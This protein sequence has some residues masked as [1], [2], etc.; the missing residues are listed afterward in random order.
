MAVYIP[1]GHGG[2]FLNKPRKT[3]PDGCSLTVI[4]TCGGKTYVG[5]HTNQTFEYDKINAFLREHPEKRNIFSDP[6]ANAADLNQIFGSVAI[7]GPGEKYPNIAYNLEL[8]W[9]NSNLDIIDMRYSGLIPFD[10]YISPEFTSKNIVD[11]LHIDADTYTDVEKQIFP[12]MAELGRLD[13]RAVFLRNQLEIYKYSLFPTPADYNKYF[14]NG[15]AGLNQVF[16]D[17]VGPATTFDRLTNV[18]YRY[19][20]ARKIFSGDMFWNADKD[21]REG[22]VKV[23]LETL[24]SKFPGHYIHTV[25]RGLEGDLRYDKRLSYNS[26]LEHTKEEILTKRL[27][28]MTPAQKKQAVANIEEAKKVKYRKSRFT[29]RTTKHNNNILL[30]GLRKSLAQNELLGEFSKVRQRRPPTNAAW[31]GRRRRTRKS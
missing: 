8:A 14:G 9:D 26:V 27:P 18:R 3:I 23:S 11:K 12:N 16:E 10:T 2:E 15:D 31:G 4:E 21:R 7:Y 25:C 6:K 20:Q 1:I 13:N 17:R 19:M 22:F 24:M 5:N 30:T 29:Q 28:G